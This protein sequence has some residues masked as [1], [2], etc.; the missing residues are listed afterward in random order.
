MQSLVDQRRTRPLNNRERRSGP[1]VY[2]MSR[3]Q[4]VR[5]N[6]ALLHAAELARDSRQPLAVVFCL[7]PSYLGATL[8]QYD[9]MLSGLAGVEAEL[10]ECGIH[11]VL[12]T[13]RPDEQVVCFVSEHGVGAVVSDFN[14]LRPNRE[15]KFS[16]ARSLDVLF[17]EV[18]AH[19]IVPC[20]LAS[21]KQ[22][23]SARTFR[24]KVGAQLAD[25][26][27]P[28]TR[29]PRRLRPW[30]G[31]PARTNW[32]AVRR[33]LLIDRSVLPVADVRSGSPAA[34][35]ALRRFV[36]GRLARYAG[37]RN[38]PNADAVSGLSPYLHFGQLS[39]QRVALAVRAARAQDSAKEAFLEQLIVRRELADNYCLHCRDYDRFAG[40]PD[41]SRR[42]LAE[43]RADRREYVY[44]KAEFEQARTHDQLWNA[45]Q[46]EL[47]VAGRMHGYLRMYWAKKILEWSK[48]P[49]EAVA[50]AV[51]LNDRCALDGRD[52]NGYVGVL[53]SAGGLHD[54]PWFTR[55]VYGSVRYMSRAGCVAKF[56]VETYVGRWGCVDRSQHRAI[57]SA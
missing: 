38:D 11:F 55:P 42:T 13:G 20:W 9:F 14:P 15:W 56:D 23:Y 27:L 1:V 52:P 6:W 18:D 32:S 5:D 46:R 33:S 28:F 48:S 49:E 30:P 4:R 50:T 43:H 39:A 25:F 2:W 19:N 12:L 37:G 47:A 7:A 54:R 51:H 10:R 8:R 31:R 57:I 24:P 17:V 45:A 40:L 16:A 53:W 44:G 3:D 34:A 36:S 41:W 21:P 35:A 26:L 22:E 29:L